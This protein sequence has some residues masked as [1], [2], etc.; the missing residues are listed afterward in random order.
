MNDDRFKEIE[1][2]ATEIRKILL[3]ALLLAK[4]I[5]KDELEQNQEGIEVIKTMEQAE[6]A[7]INSSLTDSLEKLED[8]IDVIHKRAKGIY[9]LMEYVSKHKK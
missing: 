6:E 3:E 5:W 4:D 7:F 9:T 8:V 2:K 1:N